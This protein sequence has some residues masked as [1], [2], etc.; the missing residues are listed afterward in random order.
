MK[1]SPFHEPS[2]FQPHARV[3][4]IVEILASVFERKCIRVDELF[5]HEEMEFRR[6]VHETGTASSTWR[7][8]VGVPA[9]VRTRKKRLGGR[10][11][12][13]ASE[14]RGHGVPVTA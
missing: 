3:D 10:R 13:E 4:E 7:V 8:I 5:A 2:Y 14:E 6:Q 9:S 1:H 11:G 12:G